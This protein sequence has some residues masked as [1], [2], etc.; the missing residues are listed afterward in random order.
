MINVIIEATILGSE[1]PREEVLQSSEYQML[2]EML[3]DARYVSADAEGKMY[4]K[5]MGYN[6]HEN[7]WFVTGSIID[8]KTLKGVWIPEGQAFTTE[9]LARESFAE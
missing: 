7:A 8:P 9:K 6:K 3:V 4:Y 2:K 1:L 5:V